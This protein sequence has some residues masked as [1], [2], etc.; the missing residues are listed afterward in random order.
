MRKGSKSLDAGPV[1]KCLQ[2]GERGEQEEDRDRSGYERGRRFEKDNWVG[3][4]CV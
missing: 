4:V 2:L 1:Q 3:R